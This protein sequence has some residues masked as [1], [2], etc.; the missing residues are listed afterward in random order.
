MP[1][2]ALFPECTAR[3]HVRS[4]RQI[5]ISGSG[6]IHYVRPSD[7]AYHMVMKSHV[8]HSVSA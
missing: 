6:S 5:Y 2:F 7:I 3:R 1:S 8:P 4:V